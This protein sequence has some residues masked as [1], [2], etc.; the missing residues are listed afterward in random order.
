M[1]RRRFISWIA[2]AWSAFTA[3]LMNLS[4]STARMMFPNVL[5]EKPLT[6]KAGLPAEVRDGQVDER[7]KQSEGV[8]LVRDGHEIYALL[9]VCTH[10]GCIVAWN[11]GEKSWDCP[12]HGSRFDIEGNVLNGPAIAGLKHLVEHV[13]VHHR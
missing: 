8:W 4:A 3:A 1:T 13:V 12:C 2:L 6:F 5:F 9:A 7:F 10:L 11:P